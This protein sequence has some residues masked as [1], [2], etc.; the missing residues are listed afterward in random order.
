MEASCDSP[1][2]FEK[3]KNL[4]ERA[5][6][7]ASLT[8]EGEYLVNEISEQ[9]LLLEGF[10]T[11]ELDELERANLEIERK[12]VSISSIESCIDLALLFLC[13][14]AKERGIQRKIDLMHCYHDSILN[15][16]VDTIDLV[17]KLS[18]FSGD[19]ASWTQPLLKRIVSKEIT[20]FMDYPLGYNKS[21]TQELDLGQVAKLCCL[22]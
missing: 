9:S 18:Q 17:H 13:K 2:S 22:N 6:K 1:E 11:D 15:T 21:T 19:N 3:Q 20:T 10:N 7:D 14:A 5:L 4:L 16:R 12:I 8:A